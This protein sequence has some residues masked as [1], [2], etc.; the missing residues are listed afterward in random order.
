MEIE[1]EIVVLSGYQDNHR[2]VDEVLFYPA[3][4]VPLGGKEAFSCPERHLEILRDELRRCR[5]Y[6]FIGFSGADAHVLKLFEHLE[7]SKIKFVN[8]SRDAGH[9][10]L[11]RLAEV[12]P[13]FVGQ[14]GEM[15]FDGGF[16]KFVQSGELR[17]FLV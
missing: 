7:V 16:T 1:N 14:F 8:G 4:A 17:K 2:V 12:N 13:Q 15:L 3:L 10:T 5:D 11:M 9:S 6:L